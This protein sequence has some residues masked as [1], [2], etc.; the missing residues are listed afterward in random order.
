MA[1]F[2]SWEGKEK[3]CEQVIGIETTDDGE[4]IPIIPLTSDILKFL[5]IQVTV[6]P[7]I[8]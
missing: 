5:M 1:I 8:Q 7:L 2:C 4:Y 3:D 6:V